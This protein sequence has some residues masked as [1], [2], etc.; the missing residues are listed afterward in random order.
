[1]DFLDDFGPAMLGPQ[2]LRLL[3]RIIEDSTVALND[4]GQ[5][6]PSHLSST[7]LVLIK[8]GPCGKIDIARELGVSHQL[9][10][11][12][13]SKIKK[14]GLGR[15]RSDPKDGRRTIISL[16]RK[17]RA[18]TEKLIAFTS[19]LE[20]AYLALFDELEI[21][22]CDATIR[23]RKA[24]ETMPLSDRIALQ[25]KPVTEQTAHE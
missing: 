1:M 18:Q 17:G 23:V 15:E 3:N 9:T 24:L 2:L 12:R 10:A 5:Y 20:N 13:I 22:L 6:F 16:T 11:H 7:L 4:N 14:L 21:D 19:H 8:R 25:I